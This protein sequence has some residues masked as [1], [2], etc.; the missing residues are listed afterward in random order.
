MISK[1]RYKNGVLKTKDPDNIIYTYDELRD[2]VESSDAL[3]EFLEERISFSETSKNDYTYHMATYCFFH[4][5]KV[6]DLVKEYKE[7][8]KKEHDSEKS[9][10]VRKDLLQYARHQVENKQSKGTILNKQSRVKTFLKDNSVFCR[11]SKFS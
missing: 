5:K 1:D 11:Y 7:D 4:Q 8:Q 9:Y 3:E 10:K 2:D 6:D